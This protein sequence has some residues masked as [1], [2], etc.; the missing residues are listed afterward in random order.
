MKNGSCQQVSAAGNCG[1][2][3]FSPS[4]HAHDTARFPEFNG[5]SRYLISDHA[6]FFCIYFRND[7]S[8]EPF[9][10]CLYSDWQGSPDTPYFPVQR[11]FAHRRAIGQ[12]LGPELMRCDQHSQSDGQIECSGVFAKI[13]G[14]QVAQGLLVMHQPLT[15][16]HRKRIVRLAAEHR[17]PAVYGSREAVDDGGL[18]AFGPSLPAI[19]RRAAT[20][21]D[22]ILKGAKP[23]DL[24]V[25]Q[26]TK[27]ELVI[28][29]KTAKA[30]GLT[31]P[32][33]L[34]QRADQVIE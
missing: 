30:L 27:F 20:F 12:L 8:F 29:L 31:I 18:M 13:G 33:S 15:F 28:N 3:K 25:E 21:V 24:P 1:T 10:S 17:L 7:Q 19:Y 16:V 32:P 22:R 4:H 5:T 26:P 6:C 2:K 9:F 11:Q 34:L 14:G 23:A